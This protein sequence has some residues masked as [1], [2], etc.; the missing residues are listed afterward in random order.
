[1][2]AGPQ[3]G[4]SSP[5]YLDGDDRGHQGRHR[6]EERRVER[7]DDVGEREDIAQVN[8]VEIGHSQLS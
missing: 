4:P 8:H 1:M 3:S 7:S 5:A 2:V 6:R